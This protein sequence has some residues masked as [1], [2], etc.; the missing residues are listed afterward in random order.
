MQI[1]IVITAVAL[2]IMLNALYVAAEFATISAR[3]T[4]VQSLAEQGNRMAQR[5]LPFLQDTKKLDRYIAACQVGITISSLLV[6]FYGQAQL[7]PLL[8]PIMPA[9][10]AIVLALVVLTSLQ[11]ILGELLPKSIALRFPERLSIAT[12]LPMLW[13]LAIL[14]PFIAFL[15]GSALAILRSLKLNKSKEIHVH[16]PEELEFIFNDSAAVGYIDA[17]EREMLENALVLEKRLARHIMV[18]R[19][20]MIV[21]RH[22]MAAGALLKE[23]AQ[24]PCTRFPVYEKD[25]D[26]IIGLVHLKDLFLLAQATP[27]SDISSIIRPIPIVPESNSVDELWQEMQQSQSYMAVL[28]D[29]YGG[30][31]GLVTFEDI[32]EE[33]VGE[34]QDEFDAEIRPIHHSDA[35]HVRVRG[36][37]LVSVVNKKFLLHLESGAAETIGGLVSE[38]L[39]RIPQVGEV[40]QLEDIHICVEKVEADAVTLVSISLPEK[41]TTDKTKDNVTDNEVSA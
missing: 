34:L 8:E 30:T 23:L 33:I 15:N 3:R 17:G 27:E 31:A 22:D 11:V 19:G 18:P 9:G 38:K 37:V 10:V 28:F 7:A 39:E 5:L 25:I 13:S 4:R 6:G 2:L 32:V 40:L 14:R 36:D 35:N 1:F 24:T 16:S 21:A 29:E 41:N 26:H 12:T 20:R